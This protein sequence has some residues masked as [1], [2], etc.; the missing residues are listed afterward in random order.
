MFI[1]LFVLQG[2]LLVDENLCEQKSIIVVWK[3]EVHNKN[4]GFSFENVKLS[5]NLDNEM[6]ICKPSYTWLKNNKY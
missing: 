4:G 3:V 1:V 2:N 6:Q 5:I